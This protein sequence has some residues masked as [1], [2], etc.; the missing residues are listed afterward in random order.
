MYNFL[1]HFII[2]LIEVPICFVNYFWQ[3]VSK[4]YLLRCQVGEGGSIKVR[5]DFFIFY[6][7]YLAKCMMKF[8]FSIVH[9]VLPRQRQQAKTH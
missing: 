9:A 2:N 5:L 4:V 3:V 8:S 7:P 1:A 6:I